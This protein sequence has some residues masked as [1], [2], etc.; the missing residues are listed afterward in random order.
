MNGFTL[1]GYKYCGPGNSLN[2]GLPSN[3]LDEA[4]LEHDK[5]YGT[6]TAIKYFVYNKADEKLRKVALKSNTLAGRIVYTYF[7]GK[8]LFT[9]SLIKRRSMSNKYTLLMSKRDDE[10]NRLF[11]KAARGKPKGYARLASNHRYRSKVYAPRSRIY[12]KLRNYK[13]KVRKL[14]F[15]RKKRGRYIK[16]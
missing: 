10:R 6:N 2:N 4:C 16:K 3:S 15:A 12:R 8:K 11:K 7:T 9:S 13:P 1:P 14:R 5:D